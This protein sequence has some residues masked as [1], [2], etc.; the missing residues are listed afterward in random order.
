LPA[1]L[2][3]PE[4]RYLDFTRLAGKDKASFLQ[5]VE[6]RAAARL[7]PFIPI[8]PEE[9]LREFAKLGFHPHGLFLPDDEDERRKLTIRVREIGAIQRPDERQRQYLNL[10]GECEVW[11]QSGVEGHW[12][13]QQALA[14][15]RAR[16]RIAAQ[17][18]RAGKT[19]EAAMECVAVAH[20]RPRSWC[21]LVGPTMKLADRAFEKVMTTV[22]DLGLETRRIRDQGQ[23]K[24]IILANGSK[25]E[26]VSAENVWSMAG[27]AID[28]AVIDEAAQILPEVWIRGVL[29]PLMDRNGQALLISS[30]EGE[31]DFFQNK[32]LEAETERRLKGTNASWELF[33]DA[34]YDVNFYVFP[35]GEQTPALIDA[36][37]EM[38]PHEYLEQ[39]GAV[40]ATSRDRVFPE[41]K[42]KVH[43]LDQDYNPELPVRLV[44]DPSG[45]ANPY[46]VL[47]I[48][49]YS[50]HFVI[51][52]EIYRDHMS[53]EEI[54]A[55]LIE[56]PWLN[57]KEI[58]SDTEFRKK[59]ELINCTDMIVDSAASEDIRTWIKLGFPAYGVPNKPQ[60]PDRLPIMKNWL[61]DP[62]R[63]RPFW[64][65]RRDSILLDMGKTPGDIIT[66]NREEINALVIRVEESLSDGDRMTRDTTARLRH[67]S[68]V[69]VHPRCV[70]TIAEF[71]AYAFPKKRRLNMN[72]REVPRDWMNHA[73]DCFGYYLWTHK[74]FHDEDAEGGYDYLS[75][76]VP[77]PDDEEEIVEATVEAAVQIIRAGRNPWLAPVSQAFTEQERFAMFK[78]D[79][80]YRTLQ[81]PQQ[82]YVD[83]V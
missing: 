25:I 65:D 55:L 44:V 43:V 81:P 41:F 49:D 38:D 9:R 64:K 7:V 27:A 24:Q 78:T 61:R 58:P 79:L 15:S 16:F 36:A 51:F 34:S 80:R 28:F 74:R 68:R 71:K 76:E 35:Q 75:I 72:Y 18:R 33:Q 2:E 1:N 83:L 31:G 22:Q 77:P 73:M 42:D 56:K 29:P 19:T 39:F 5:D 20:G 17:G 52:D 21:W 54:A 8:T 40:P 23:E 59:W 62:D 30:W 12:N 60:V 10:Q 45:G 57:A 26:A 48:Q 47:A 63:Y 50:D 66:M 11:Q 13:G 53:T 70:H 14:R 67:C 4:L 3:T 37:K 82:T 32:A 46:C 69:R 6:D